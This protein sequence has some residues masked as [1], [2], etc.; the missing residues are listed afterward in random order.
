MCMA[1]S[2]MIVFKCYVNVK[3][4][5]R[6]V[7]CIWLF[8]SILYI[9]D[10]CMDDIWWHLSGT[11]CFTSPTLKHFL[12]SINYNLCF[13]N[14]YMYICVCVFVGEYQCTAQNIIGRYVYHTSTLIKKKKLYSQTE[15]AIFT[16]IIVWHINAENISN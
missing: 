7:Y 11:V 14:L 4:L 12:D 16:G 2:H 9:V 5:I 10:I 8:E 6:H 3:R 1:D 13:S 15:I